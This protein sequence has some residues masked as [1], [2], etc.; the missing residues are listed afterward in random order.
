VITPTLVKYGASI[1]AGCIIVWGVTIGQ[2]ALVGAG[3]V[4]THD[5]LPHAL[6]FGNPA[7]PHG[8]VCRCARRL[9]NVHQDEGS[10]RGWCETCGRECSI[11]EL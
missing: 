10:L 6:V 9:I 2:F 11:D 7:R 1:V 4:V 5:V 8:Y 3:A